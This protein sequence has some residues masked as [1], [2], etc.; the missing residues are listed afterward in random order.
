M[1]A[2]HDSLGNSQP[3]RSTPMR[4]ASSEQA[5]RRDRWPCHTPDLTLGHRI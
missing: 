5:D 1:L 4:L 2:I 3:L